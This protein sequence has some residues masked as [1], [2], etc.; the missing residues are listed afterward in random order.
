[1]NEKETYIKAF[2]PN[3]YKIIKNC[4]TKDKIIDELILYPLNLFKDIH[5]ET[6]KNFPIEYQKQLEN[7]PM[8]N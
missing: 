3:T 8:P 6:I 4:K 2:L 1:M 7:N 5:E